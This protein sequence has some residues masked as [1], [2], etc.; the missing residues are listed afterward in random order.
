MRYIAHY[1]IRRMASLISVVDSEELPT[2]KD[3]EDKLL[4][5]T[6]GVI[7]GTDN[8][9]EI[10]SSITELWETELSNEPEKV[11][12]SSQKLK[13]RKNS[14]AKESNCRW[15]RRAFDFWEGDH[16]VYGCITLS[17]K[18]NHSNPIAQ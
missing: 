17:S 12:K 2:I 14:A 15:Y 18:I 11:S 7:E 16:L 8:N 3:I 4:L 13:K 5:E 6:G 10:Y 1:P 9:D